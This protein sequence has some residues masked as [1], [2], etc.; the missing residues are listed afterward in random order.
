[1]ELNSLFP[2]L[3]EQATAVKVK[4]FFNKDFERLLRLADE[5]NKFFSLAE[6]RRYAEVT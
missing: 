1:M 6:L 2:V 5:Q 4:N 3:D